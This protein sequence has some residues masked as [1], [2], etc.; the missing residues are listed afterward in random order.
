SR[1]CLQDCDA[2]E[3]LRRPGEVVVAVS[4]HRKAFA[5][6]WQ[7]RMVLAG[8]VP[9]YVVSLV[10]YGQSNESGPEGYNQP[11][12]PVPFSHAVHAG[13]ADLDC[14]YC[15]TTVDTSN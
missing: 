8:I 9:V 2:G 10:L 12:Q 5:R 14:R 11:T 15:H 13:A 1:Q 3:G 4:P 6:I 7:Y